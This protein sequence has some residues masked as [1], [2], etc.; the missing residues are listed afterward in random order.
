MKVELN[1]LKA[2]LYRQK[3]KSD[4][5]LLAIAYRYLRCN[6]CSISC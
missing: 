4:M 3:D 6:G 2:I 1:L 5:S